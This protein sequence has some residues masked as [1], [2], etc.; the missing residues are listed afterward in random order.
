MPL[1]EQHRMIRDAV[2]EFA[3]EQLAPKAAQWDRE[4]HFPREELKGLA[5]LGLFGVAI[6]E[7][8]GGAGLDG[9]SLA[10]ACE[11][12]AAGE[13]ATATIVSVTNM[14]AGIVK[15]FG[16]AAQKE[17]FLKPLARGEMLGGFAL[18]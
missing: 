4:K 10:L 12:I 1:T 18:T 8:W 11:E 14:V 2:R 16:N 13:S 7:E 5:A 3:R 9:T 17:N 6:P 15:G